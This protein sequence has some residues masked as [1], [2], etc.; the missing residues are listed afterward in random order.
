MVFKVRS[1][2]ARLL[3]GHIIYAVDVQWHVFI[4]LEEK[5]V[6]DRFYIAKCCYR[7]DFN[8]GSLAKPN[9]I[10]VW[11]WRREQNQND[12]HLAN[13]ATGASYYCWWF[14]VCKKTSRN[15]KD[16]DCEL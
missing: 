1:P 8:D 11:I 12:R 7:R 3:A 2:S 14:L 9:N 4:A 16:S 6:I 10:R 15:I 13:R 5:E